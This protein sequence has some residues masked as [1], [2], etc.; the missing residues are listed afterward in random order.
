MEHAAHAP[1]WA[2][3]IEASAVGTFMRQSIA[4]YPAANLAHLLGLV[5]L[6]GPIAL[7][8]LRVLGLGRRHLG[9]DAASRLLT[10]FAVA[11]LVVLATSGALMFSADAASLSGSAILAA[12]LCFVAAGLANAALFRVLWRRRL[13]VWDSEGPWIARAQAAGSLALWLAAASCG[14]LIAYL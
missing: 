9:A 5:L 14:R 3:A 13:P 1:E 11:G 10:P 2:A 12:K 4:A 7:F 8:D 6:V